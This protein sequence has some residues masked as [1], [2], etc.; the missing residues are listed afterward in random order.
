MWLGKRPIPVFY[1]ARYF[2]S[3]GLRC[4]VCAG[5]AWSWSWS[6]AWLKENK[7]GLARIL[8]QYAVHEYLPT[9]TIAPEPLGA[10]YMSFCVPNS[11]VTRHSNP[12]KKK[13]CC[14]EKN[15]ADHALG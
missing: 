12:K 11:A 10:G 5:M 9:I 4:T 14:L 8:A 13:R 3:T 7:K 1:M 15:G 6:W 2:A